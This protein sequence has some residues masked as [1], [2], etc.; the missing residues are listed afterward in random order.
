M[1]CGLPADDFF[2]F[3]FRFRFAHFPHVYRGRAANRDGN[4][5][6]SAE[7]LFDFESRFHVSLIGEVYPG[8]VADAIGLRFFYNSQAAIWAR[9]FDPA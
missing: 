2:R 8:T 9:Q 6:V 3:R 5:Y 7:F 4:F 1:L